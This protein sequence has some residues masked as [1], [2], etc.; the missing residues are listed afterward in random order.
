MDASLFSVPSAK[1][2]VPSIL[3]DVLSP[4]SEASLFSVQCTLSEASLFDVLSPK[5]L[6]SMCLAPRAKYSYTRVVT[7]PFSKYPGLPAEDKYN[8]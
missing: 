8:L 7:A 5:H 1:S 6:Y 3:L 2:Q 4:L